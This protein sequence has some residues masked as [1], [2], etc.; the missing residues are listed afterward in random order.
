MNAI[1]LIMAMTMAASV[2][3]RIVVGPGPEDMVLDTL[4][5][6]S[7]LLISCSGRRE[8]HKPYGEIESLDLNSG[9][10]NVLTRMNEPGN[11]K[12]RPHG[13][14][15]S[16]GHLF[17]ISHEKEPDDHPIL[18]YKV[19]GNQ[20]EFVE[21]VKG[22]YQH[23]PNA[24]VTGPK[25]EIYFVNDS[26]KRGS[27]VEKA[28]KLKR[29]NVVRL[30]KNSEGNWESAI[31]AEDL[32]YPA[33]INCIENKV[34]VGDAILHRIHVFEI[35]A[36]GLQKVS[37]I[38]GLKGNDNIRFH[39][40]NILTPGHIKPFKFIGHAKDPQKLSPVEVFL[41]DP[42]SGEF[43][44]LFETDGS[45]ISAGSTAVIH[46]GFLYICQ[47][48]DPFLLKVNLDR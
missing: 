29:A 36:S 33:G 39:Q 6:N 30:S 15:L 9:D 40:G 37:E 18:I 2:P 7:R 46:D 13:I 1:V 22:P 21:Q 31:V 28:L 25:G 24:L 35:T 5:G 27:I 14:Y 42:K 17:V 20:L 38:E 41:A 23:S 45:L 48:F 43:Q 11:I 32:G 34:F 47:V 16:K 12:F 44:I 26:G 3:E 10:R 8:E 4:N 19:N